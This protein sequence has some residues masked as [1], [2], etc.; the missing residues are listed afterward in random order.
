MQSDY[1]SSDYMHVMV[2]GFKS[3]F[4]R[5]FLQEDVVVL[6]RTE[7]CFWRG[8]ASTL[9]CHLSFIVAVRGTPGV[10]RAAS[11]G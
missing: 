6:K 5:F 7:T 1:G 9:R 3:L 2:N 11:L 10:G 4:N 8:T